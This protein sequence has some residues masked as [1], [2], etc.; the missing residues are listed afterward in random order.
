M[1][2][3]G[4]VDGE[5]EMGKVMGISVKKLATLIKSSI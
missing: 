5:G 4:E 3:G 1:V 2:V